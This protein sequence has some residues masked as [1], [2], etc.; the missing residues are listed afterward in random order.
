MQTSIINSRRIYRHWKGFDSGPGIEPEHLQT[1]IIF[2]LLYLY[3]K[4]TAHSQ[5]T[6]YRIWS[7]LTSR[8]DP[9]SFWCCFVLNP[10][11]F[12]RFRWVH[13]LLNHS[14]TAPLN[15]HFVKSTVPRGQRAVKS[16]LNPG[17]SRVKPP[18]SPGGRGAGVSIDWCISCLLSHALFE[19][20]FFF[21][22]PV[23]RKP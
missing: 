1:N 19:C 23:D 11:C 20:S 14:S 6:L 21:Y 4:L 8:A 18:A 12:P 13:V 22:L 15:R 10:G 7:V 16:V 9:L 2:T 5:H 3:F 17:Y